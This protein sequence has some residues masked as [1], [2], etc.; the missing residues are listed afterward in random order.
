MRLRHALLVV[1]C[2]F[3]CVAPA[4]A[5]AR[6]HGDYVVR[7]GAG[8][9]H[10]G[11]PY[12][13]TGLN[14]YNANNRRPECWYPMDAT[15]LDGSLTAMGA[16]LDV[17]RGWF[18][19]S[20]ATVDG[21]RDWSG[22]DTTVAVAKARG[23]R[24][25]VTLGNQWADCD[26]EGFKTAD[27]YADGYRERPA[28]LPSSYREW[29]AEVVS[30]YARE[31]TVLMWQLLNEAEVPLHT[32]D[33][34]CDEAVAHPLLKGWAADV[35]RLVKSIDRFHLVSIGTLGSGQCGA[36]YTDYA[37]LHELP[38]VDL[39]EV[40]DYGTET[41]PGDQW[42]GLAFRLQQCA[43]L[44]KPLFVGETGIDPRWLDGTLEARAALFDAKLSA[45]F[46]AGVVGEV[47]WAWNAF[48]S[49]TDT[50]D[51]GPGDPVLDVLAR[52]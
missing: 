22:F 13:F 23:V 25:I 33:G 49:R 2:A 14:V 17:V 27:W 19:Q 34:L 7:D 6:A 51:I 52:Y 37:S 1:T 20:F 8:L 12:T 15:L 31:P 50:F 11:K 26:S 42:N 41:M 30:R 40:H 10:K 43:A 3:L 45:Q 21:A 47:L 38:T 28:S 44:E 36:Q 5:A 4:A 24:L 39:C 46:G 16:G 18:F 32:P 48:E 29:V 35:S 9:W